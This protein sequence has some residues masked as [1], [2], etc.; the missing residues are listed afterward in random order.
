V[1]RQ[2]NGVWTDW[3]STNIDTSIVY[4]QPLTPGM[5]YTVVAVAFDP[6]GHRSVRS[7]RA[8]RPVG[9]PLPSGFTVNS[10]ATGPIPCTVT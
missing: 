6:S 5:T 7:D 9:S 4:L 3:S 1:Q 2:V 8:T 10:P